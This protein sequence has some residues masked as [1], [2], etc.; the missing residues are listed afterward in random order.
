MNTLLLV[1]TT[2]ISLRAGG[3]VRD[4]GGYLSH[5]QTFGFG[6]LDTSGGGV[7]E[8]GSEIAPRLSL[9]VSW[10]VFSSN[11]TKRLVKLG[12]RT[13]ALLAH[14][15]YAAWRWEG[16]VAMAQ[17]Q[18][19][20]GGG[21]YGIN[22]NFDGTIR[23]AS[24]AGVRAGADLSMYWRGLGFIFGYGYHLASAALADRIG[25]SVSAGGHEVSGGFSLRF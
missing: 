24:G 2:T 21:F 20:I 16:H 10:G 17:V 9:H 5:A 1:L 18:V 6:S 11:A 25:G 22:E 19:S 23:D 7:I 3:Y 4:D 12:L 14:V 15:R 8:A 13:D